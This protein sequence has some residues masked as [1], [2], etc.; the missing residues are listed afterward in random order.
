M[1]S[2]NYSRESKLKQDREEAK[3]GDFFFADYYNNSCQSKRAPVFVIGN[4][5]DQE[6]VIICTCTSQ[7]SRGGWDKLVQLKKPTYIRTNKIYT[8]RRNQLHFKIN[9]DLVNR[10]PNKYKEIIDSVKKA[11]NL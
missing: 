6:D 11:L 5:G 9:Y 3:H 10:L 2:E 7:A 8:I 1:N 4:D